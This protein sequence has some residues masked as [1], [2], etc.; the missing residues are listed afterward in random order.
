[1]K[2]LYALNL[3]DNAI[4]KYILSSL[5]NEYCTCLFFDGDVGG[6]PGI[7]CEGS[8]G[9]GSPDYASG[10]DVGESTGSIPGSDDCESRGTVN[11]VV[12]SEPSGSAEFP[13]MVTSQFLS[14]KFVFYDDGG[15]NAKQ[16]TSDN[17]KP[18]TCSFQKDE[19]HNN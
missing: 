3:S 8:T 12:L 19:A 11:V 10:S 15:S 18:L 1:M 7:D 9:D 13:M 4:F 14:I 17:P 2:F 5:L 16:L 6:I